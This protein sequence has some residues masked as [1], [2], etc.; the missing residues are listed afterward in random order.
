MWRT[1]TATA[2]AAALTA[3]VAWGQPPGGEG[4]QKRKTPGAEKKADF[5]GAPGFQPGSGPPGTGSVQGFPGPGGPG[6]PGGPPPKADPQVE[7]WVKTLTD[8]MN[9]PHDAIRESARAA[10]VAVGPPALPALRRIAE[11]ADAK[12]YTATRLVQ[13]IERAAAMWGAGGYGGTGSGALGQPG[14]FPGQPFP[15]GFG[16]GGAPS[17]PGTGRPVPEA[18]RP[19]PAP[20]GDAP[21]GRILG[22]LKLTDQQRQQA[23]KV[24]SGYATKLREVMDEA[25][26]GKLDRGSIRD[27]ITKLADEA[28]AE[29]K[30]ALT[31]EQRRLF[32]QLAPEGRPL[33]PT[34][35]G[36]GEAAPGRGERPD[37]NAPDRPRPVRP[38]R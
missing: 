28:T 2:C 20:R 12:A 35:F 15:G 32:E 24:V 27:T 3:T 5:P 4:P 7:A 33:F 25:R 17:L 16:P 26:S 38:E 22:E 10:L 9:D 29:L 6:G 37:P 11:G 34:P 19:D 23:E 14:G 8:K 36:P 21:L 13:Q 30:R 1:I 31:P 18:P